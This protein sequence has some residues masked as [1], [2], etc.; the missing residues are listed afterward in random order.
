MLLNISNQLLD[1][2]ASVIAGAFVMNLP[3]YSLYG[4]CLRAVGRQKHHLYSSVSSQPLHYRFRLVYAEVV[5]HYIEP[6]IS[7]RRV[8][9]IQRLE[10]FNKQP[11]RLALAYARDDVPGQMI[12]RR[13]KVALL[14]LAGGDDFNHFAF[15]HPLI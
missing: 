3:K 10:Q 15:C 8:A 14:I 9:S 11:C 5:R 6:L 7:V 13:R 4:V 2:L 12:E 1:L